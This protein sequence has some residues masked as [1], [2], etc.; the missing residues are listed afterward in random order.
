MPASGRKLPKFS[1][2][3]VSFFRGL[4][5]NNTREW[6]APRKSVFEEHVRAPM[7]EVAGAVNELVKRFAVDNAVA[8]PAK[9]LYR[10]YRDTRF[11]KDK[12]PY[13]THVGATFPRKGLPKHGG[14]GFYFGISH[15]GVGVAGGVYGPGAEELAALRRGM[16]SDAAGFLKV[17]ED[18]R[19]AKVMGKLLGERLARVPK[20]FEEHRE[21]AVAEYLKMKAIYWYVELP[22]SVAL[23]S[24]LVGE[25][26]RRFELMTPAMRWMNDAI[27]AG[28]ADEEEDA[29]VAR[30]APMW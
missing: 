18:R 27:I 15:E 26:A 13:K 24:R 10:I 14:A 6:F 20:G 30:L 17:V 22:V 4:E 5:R 16:V 2:K 8:D 1:R 7:V 12:T 9:A 29:V 11:S 19:V 25:V 21:S 3:M 28:R 23:S